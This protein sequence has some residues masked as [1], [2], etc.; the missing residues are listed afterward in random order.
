MKKFQSL[1]RSLSND[2]QKSI[3]GGTDTQLEIAAGTEVCDCNSIDDCGNGQHCYN[4][5]CTAENGC[6]GKCLN[7]Q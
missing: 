7:K 2:E 3:R 6:G 4:T 5:G 1:G